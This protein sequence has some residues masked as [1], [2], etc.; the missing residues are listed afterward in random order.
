LVDREGTIRTALRGRQV[1]ATL[2]D[3][4]ATLP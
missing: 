3:Q 2:R 1:E 4:F